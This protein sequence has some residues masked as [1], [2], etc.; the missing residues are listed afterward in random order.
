MWH[1]NILQCF[2]PGSPVHAVMLV[3]V[4]AA[5]VFFTDRDRRRSQTDNRFATLLFANFLIVLVYYLRPSQIAWSVSLP[6]HIC[7]F[8]ALAA[9]IAIRTGNRTARIILHFWGLALSSQALLFPVIQSGPAHCDFWLYWINHG[10]ILVAAIYDM[11]TRNYRPT[12]HDW[13]RATLL[14]AAYA[15][16]IA[17]FDA[18]TGLDYGFLGNT[19][20][21]QQSMVT[22]LGPWP[23]RLPIMWLIAVALMALVQCLQL[24][25]RATNPATTNSRHAPGYPDQIGRFQ[26]PGNPRDLQLAARPIAHARNPLQSAA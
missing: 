21:S 1:S 3:C 5:T 8:T 22:M 24:T 2:H 16:I 18:L 26:S 9:A 13:R 10:A 7:D 23:A 15:A 17:P 19:R 20:L 25:L 4:V 14:L 6:L 12:W 11:R